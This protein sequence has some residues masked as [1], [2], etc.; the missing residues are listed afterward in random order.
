VV[1]SELPER[2]GLHPVKGALMAV[3]LDSNI[4]EEGQTYRIGFVDP[5]GRYLDRPELYGGGFYLAVVDAKGAYPSGLHVLATGDTGR[6][7]VAQHWSL[8]EQGK[9]N[10]RA[11]DQAYIFVGMAEIGGSLLGVRVGAGMNLQRPQII[12]L[13]GPKVERTFQPPSKECHAALRAKEPGFPDSWLPP[14]AVVTEAAGATRKGTLLS[15]GKPCNE[16]PNLEVWPPNTAKSSLLSVAGST[17]KAGGGESQIIAGK[18][19]DEAWISN[20][21]RISHFDAG[22]IE[23]L[24]ELPGELDAADLAIDR[25]G[26]LFVKSQED[27]KWKGSARVVTTPSAL[28]RWSG[29]Q[30]ELVQ[31]PDAPT[32]L[33][34]ADDGTLWISAG[35]ALLRER[36]SAAD[37]S[38]SVATEAENKAIRRRSGA[39]GRAPGP[40]C[41]Q[42][43]VVLYGFTKVTPDD[44]DFP[45]TRKAIKGHTEFDKVRFVVARDGGQKFLSAI[46]PDAQTGRKLTS[47]IEKQ[48]KG[49]KPQLVC[50]EPEIL[51]DMKI[52][53]RSGELIKP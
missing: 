31:T 21:G 51:R 46:V 11:W 33:A 8:S 4:S 53:L 48:V 40:L 20:S 7:A 6:I 19:E 25:A 50:A 41:P 14:A 52:D 38:M 17:R 32:S 37:E 22:A 43:L 18:G 23:A 24:P 12:T 28:Y 47:L 45:S 36:L 9:W 44:Y 26:T 10:Q 34:T 1:V 13:L 2:M 29:Q 39:L 30:W 16:G 49:S 27:M 3:G 42:N 35:R 15:V 5:S